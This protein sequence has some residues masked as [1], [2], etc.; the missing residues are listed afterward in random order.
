MTKTLYSLS[1]ADKI[2]SADTLHH[3]FLIKP[4]FVKADVEYTD[5]LM[6]GTA[7]NPRWRCK[8]SYGKYRSGYCFGSTLD[9]AKASVLHT[10]I[11]KWF[12]DSSTISE[13]S[14]ASVMWM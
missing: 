13:N 10:L 4:D 8:G 12:N 7:A 6:L 2:T 3:S 11:S 14:Y 5:A 1:E 9:E